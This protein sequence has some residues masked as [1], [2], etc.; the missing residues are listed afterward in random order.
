MNYTELKTLLAHGDC[1]EIAKLCNL[2]VTY[3]QNVWKGK[4]TDTPSALDVKLVTLL[5]IAKR[6]QYQKEILE[7][8]H[9]QREQRKAEKK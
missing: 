2:S 8:L 1:K 6:E 5:K 9:A 4:V 3:V 7:A